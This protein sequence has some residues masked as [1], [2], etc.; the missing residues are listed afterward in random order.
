MSEINTFQW[1]VSMTFS[2]LIENVTFPK[3]SHGTLLPLHHNI[4]IWSPHRSYVIIFDDLFRLFLHGCSLSL[5]DRHDLLFPQSRTTII[6]Q[7]RA[8]IPLLKLSQIITRHCFWSFVNFI[9]FQRKVTVL[10]PKFRCLWQ[11]LGQRAILPPTGF[12]WPTDCEEVTAD[13]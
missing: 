8:L 7:H 9:W 10:F 11:I 1:E 3:F 4:I 12:L 6:A 13:W 5:L 2:T